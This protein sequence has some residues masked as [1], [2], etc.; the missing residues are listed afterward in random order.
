[1]SCQTPFSLQSLSQKYWNI[2]NPRRVNR[3]YN[4]YT[5][6]IWVKITWSSVWGIPICTAQ[7]RHWEQLSKS[8]SN[9]S[10][11][12]CLLILTLFKL[13]GMFEEAFPRHQ[14]W[15]CTLL[16]AHKASC[17][18]SIAVI[19]SQFHKVACLFLY[20]SMDSKTMRTNHVFISM[21]P[22]LSFKQSLIH[23]RSSVNICWMNQPLWPGHPLTFPASS[24]A[25]F[26][27]YF[28]FKQQSV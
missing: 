6:Y 18:Y 19:L 5:S 1:M 16:C 4:F 9:E 11:N 20:S 23:S 27:L 26:A 13:L 15:I 8:L 12:F 17:S 24:P 14:Y 28:S 10:Y 2:Q 7:S 22:E 25:F 21:F 3:Q